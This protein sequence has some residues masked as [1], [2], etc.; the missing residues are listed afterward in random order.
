MTNENDVKWSFWKGIFPWILWSLGFF[1]LEFRGIKE[2][3][4]SLPPLTFVIRRWIPGWL[5]FM[6]VGWIAWHFTLTYLSLLLPFH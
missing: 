3:R 1:A 6:G 2:K 5:L 4:D